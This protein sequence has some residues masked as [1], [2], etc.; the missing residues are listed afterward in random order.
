MK[1]TLLFPLVFTA[2]AS[3]AWAQDAANGKKLFDDQCVV[4]HAVTE[5]NGAG[6][7]LKGVYGRK[8]AG[9]AGFRYS[10][11]I[12]GAAFTWD[13]KALDT[14][15]NDPQ[16]QVPGGTMPFSGIADAKQRA[17]LIAYLKTLK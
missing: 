15:L 14:Y 3:P 13:D 11:A 5:K 16:Q 17:D 8:P 6:P 12:K 9:T 10:R 7:G 1:K 4:C 2:I